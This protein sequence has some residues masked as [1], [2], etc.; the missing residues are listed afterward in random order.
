MLDFVWATVVL[1]G[2][3][4]STLN[5]TDFW[6][7]TVILVGEGA[8]VFG[9]SHELEWQ[10]HTTQTST[11]GGALR[12]SSHFFRHIVHALVDPAAV[13]AATTTMTRAPGPRCSSARSSRS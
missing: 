2:G 6:C 4:A 11:A 10:Q 3:F 5:I 13:A 8:R 7:V 12:S 9:R 1:L